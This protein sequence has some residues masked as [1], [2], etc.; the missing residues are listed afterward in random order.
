MKNPHN[1]DDDESICVVGDLVDDLM[2][3]IQRDDDG[4]IAHPE[5]ET[6]S[7]FHAVQQAL[8]DVDRFEKREYLQALKKVPELVKKESPWDDFMWTEDQ[9]VNRAALRLCRYWKA[10]RFAFGED[11]WL[12]PLDQ[13]GSV[14]LDAQDIEILRSGYF[15]IVVR[16]AGGIVGIMDMTR[17]PIKGPF[18]SPVRVIFYLTMLYAKEIRKGYYSIFIEKA[19][20]TPQFSLSSNNWAL[21]HVAFPVKIWQRKV[22]VVRASFEAGREALVDYTT[23]Q[24]QQSIRFVSK[25]NVARI[26]GNS[27]SETFQMLQ[28]ASGGVERQ[29]LPRCIGGTFDYNLFFE[30][31][32]K[33]LSVELVQVSISSTSLSFD[34]T[35]VNA[36]IRERLQLMRNYDHRSNLFLLSAQ[37]S[38]E[39]DCSVENTD[40]EGRVE[41][42]LPKK[43]PSANTP[44]QL[45]WIDYRIR[46]N[47]EM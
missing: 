2:D 6:S 10:R 45:N 11:R 40:C 41:I 47:L 42:P 27:L 4:D 34:Q 37:G 12:R 21:Y 22:F 39:K 16:P 9:N 46:P 14:A 1:H 30:W 18:V 38:T 31:T 35:W 33:R 29:C 25:S 36:I 26:M 8:I 5:Y 19:S 28:E 20:P 7:S 15:V 17:L 44:V 23:Y 24:R 43:M 32:R 3:F 13:T